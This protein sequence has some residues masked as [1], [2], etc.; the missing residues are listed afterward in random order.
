MVATQYT[1]VTLDSCKENVVDLSKDR[2][3]GY[4]VCHSPLPLLFKIQ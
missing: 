3:L 2:K 1:H 4:C